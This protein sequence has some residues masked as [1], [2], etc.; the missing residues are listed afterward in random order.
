MFKLTTI[1]RV[2]TNEP[3]RLKLCQ[4]GLRS[5]AASAHDIPS[6]VELTQALPENLRLLPLRV[7]VTLESAASFAGLESRDTKIED[8]GI[9]HWDVEWTSKRSFMLMQSLASRGY[10]LVLEGFGAGYSS[11]ASLNRFSFDKLELHHFFFADSNSSEIAVATSSLCR[12]LGISFVAG[13]VNYE[14][15]LPTLRTCGCLEYTSDRAS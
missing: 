3:V 12:S 1:R 5:I 10:R 7:D 8:L 4:D 11:V 9:A 15:S 2:E 13:L 6:I 14:S